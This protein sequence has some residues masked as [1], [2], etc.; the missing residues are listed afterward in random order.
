MGARMYRPG[1]WSASVLADRDLGQR[2]PDPATVRVSA[3]GRPWS[4]LLRTNPLRWLAVA[5]LSTVVAGLLYAATTSAHPVPPAAPATVPAPAP[6]PVDVL[7]L[8]RIPAAAAAPAVVVPHAAKKTVVRATRSHTRVH[9]RARSRTSISSWRLPPSDGSRGAIALR[10]ALAQVGTPYRFGA[11]GNGAFDC[12]GLVMASWKQAGVSL[13]HQ[14][15]AI[16]SKGTRVPAGQ[17]RPG[18]VVIMKHHVAIYAGNGKMVEA[19]KPGK[20]VR[21]VDTRGGTARRM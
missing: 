9:T 4:A 13:P 12:S 6:Q 18:D 10:W 8:H 21:V 3:R 16:A 15:G 2:G 1:L 19:P 20:T 17:W 11:A 14:S 7:Q 5:V